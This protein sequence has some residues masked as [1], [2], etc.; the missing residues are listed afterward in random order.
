M[1]STFVGVIGAVAM[2]VGLGALFRQVRGALTA[3]E[4]TQ[5]V[6]QGGT[7][8]AISQVV[9]GVALLVG[10]GALLYFALWAEGIA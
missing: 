6:V 8:T 1:M 7:M 9:L 3:G 4:S 5:T 10:G 2:A